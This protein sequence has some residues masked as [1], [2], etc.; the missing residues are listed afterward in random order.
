MD[1]ITSIM[2]AMATCMDATNTITFDLWSSGVDGKSS[3]A[4]E[5]AD[6]ITNWKQN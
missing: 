2:D 1:V 5:Q 3:T 4:T 6:D